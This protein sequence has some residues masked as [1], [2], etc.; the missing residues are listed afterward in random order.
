MMNDFR[1]CWGGFEESSGVSAKI[2]LLSCWWVVSEVLESFFDE[3]WDC[4]WL[5]KM[6]ASGLEAIFVSD[7]VELD[8]L[9][10]G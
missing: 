4:W 8:V 3:L 7:V 10:F 5:G 6:V 2:R 1:K 9:A